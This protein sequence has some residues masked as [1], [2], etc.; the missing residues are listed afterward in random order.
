M[1][2]VLVVIFGFCF[3]S[4]YFIKELRGDFNFKKGL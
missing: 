2:Y 1:M 4:M 3:L